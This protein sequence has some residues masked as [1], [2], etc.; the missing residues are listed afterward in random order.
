MEIFGLCASDSVL[1]GM[2]LAIA[3]PFLGLGFFLR[4]YFTRKDDSNGGQ[5]IQVSK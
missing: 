4:P 1:L 2:A 3:T 5:K